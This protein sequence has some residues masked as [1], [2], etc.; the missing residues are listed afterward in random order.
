M[1]L[2]RFSDPSDLRYARASRRGTWEGT[3]ARRVR[4]LVIEWEP[5]SDLVGD[6]TWPG[7]DTDIV[8]MERVGKALKEAGVTGFELAPVQ[9]V[10]NSEESKRA[11]KKPRVKLPYVGPQLWDLWVT[12]RA[13]LDRDRSSVKMLGKQADGSEQYEVSG[14]ERREAIWD[15]QRMELVKRRHPRID[16]Q[17]LFVR[18]ETGIFRIAEFPGWILCVDEVKQLIE[19][20]SLTNVSFL[21][22]GEVVVADRIAV[23]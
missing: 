10:D 4:P 21:E 22:M 14:V 7:F 15:Q 13:Q 5:D 1:K 2:W 8:I 20:H 19:S 6:F 18:A 11:S 23:V 3:P 17:G 12:A 16:G 9:M